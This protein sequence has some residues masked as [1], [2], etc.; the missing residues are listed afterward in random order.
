[1]WF[2][3]IIW[4][5]SE[6]PHFSQLIVQFL[7]VKCV[8]KLLFLSW[9]RSA[10]IARQ[11]CTTVHTY[12]FNELFNI[13]IRHI[14]V[15]EEWTVTLTSST[16]TIYLYSTEIALQKWLWVCIW[17][18]LPG[19]WILLQHAR[20]FGRSVLLLQAAHKI[21]S[22][23]QAHLWS[24]SWSGNA[25]Q[26]LAN[27]LALNTAWR[28]YEVRRLFSRSILHLKYEKKAHPLLLR[29]FR[30]QAQIRP[31]YFHPLGVPTHLPLSHH[32]SQGRA[33][34]DFTNCWHIATYML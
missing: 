20:T 4:T 14:A 11:R 30:R 34:S 31:C 22:V 19:I 7:F 18:Y 32:F 1:M 6:K 8:C 9:H 16:S 27:K 26:F 15:V 28:P 21:A 12:I 25:N 13:S 33:G 2:C 3:S 29:D 24:I 17:I 23:V 5:G 10:K